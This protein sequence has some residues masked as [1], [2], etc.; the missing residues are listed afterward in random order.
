MATRFAGRGA[1]GVGLFGITLA[2]EYA[3]ASRLGVDPAAAYW[4]ERSAMRRPRRWLAD[5]GA[6]AY[7]TAGRP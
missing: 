5:V 7:G 2:D 1:V 4:R 6:R 3:L